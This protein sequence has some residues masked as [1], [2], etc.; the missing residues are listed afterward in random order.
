MVSSKATSVQ[1]YLNEL[2]EDRRATISAVRDV[3]LRN[4]PDG[5]SET[6]NWGM[7]TYE[8]PLARYPNTYNG[9][10]LAYASLAAQ[11]NFNAVYLNNIYQDS[12]EEGWLR[13]EFK[14]AGKK[15]DMGKSCVRFRKLEDIP[16]EAIGKVVASTPLDEFIERYE[17]SRRF[18][19]S[20]RPVPPEPS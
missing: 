9:Q 10:P 2:P 7:I 5:Y 20:A 1:A 11:K 4:L 3:I 12:Q 13:E 15:L 16:L 17:A 6:M 18:K 8:V 19:A 14:K